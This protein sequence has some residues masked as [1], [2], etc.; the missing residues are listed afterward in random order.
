MVQYLSKKA[1]PGEATE[2][3]KFSQKYQKTCESEHFGEQWFMLPPH[4][5][6]SQG[7]RKGRSK[8][9]LART[10]DVAVVISLKLVFGPCG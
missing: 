3:H 10:P 7:F 8:G 2:N 6:G 1:G 9:N 5:L 4:V